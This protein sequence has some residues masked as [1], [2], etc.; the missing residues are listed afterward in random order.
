MGETPK[1]VYETAAYFVRLFLKTDPT[2]PEEQRLS[3]GVFHKAHGVLF[4]TTQSYGHAMTACQDLQTYVD[5]VLA[6]EN[7]P[8]ATSAGKVN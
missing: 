4:A 3:Y 7:Q 6:R 5:E 1:T 2:L 8:A